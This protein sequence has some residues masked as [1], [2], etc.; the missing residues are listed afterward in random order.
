MVHTVLENVNHCVTM[1]TVPERIIIVCAGGQGAIVAD[2]LQRARD[3]GADALAIGF[4]DDTPELAGTAVLGV[5]VLGPIASLSG[6]AHDAVIVALGD[7][8]AR[9]A[10]TE[11]LLAAG[12]RLATAIHPRACVAPSASVG[13]GSMISA[14]AVISPRANIGRGVIINTNA[15]VDHDTVVEDFAHVSSGA[16]VGARCRIGAESLIG[17]GASVLS[18]AIVGARTVIGSGAA[19]VAEI[20]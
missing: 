10:M 11:R 1:A 15:S 14:G 5:D 8:E 2:I 20:P 13:E 4:V 17:L 7:N 6:I 19:V 16:T 18:G 12:E 3:A 9:R